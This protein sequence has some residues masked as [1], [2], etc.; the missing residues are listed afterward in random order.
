MYYTFILT[1]IYLIGNELVKRAQNSKINSLIQTIADWDF[2]N[3][4]NSSVQ[5]KPTQTYELSWF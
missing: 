5:T 4:T 2:L 1:V 3:K